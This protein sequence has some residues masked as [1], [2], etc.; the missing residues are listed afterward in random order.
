MTRSHFSG[1]RTH[2]YPRPSRACGTIDQRRIASSSLFPLRRSRRRRRR[3]R[4]RAAAERG[5]ERNGFSR[6]RRL[7][8]QGNKHYTF[9]QVL[10][11]HLST[12]TGFSQG[13]EAAFVSSLQRSR[14]DGIVQTVLLIFASWEICRCVGFNTHEFV[15]IYNATSTT[16]LHKTSCLEFPASL[17]KLLETLLMLKGNM[18]ACPCACWSLYLSVSVPIPPT[19]LRRG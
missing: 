5:G 15:Y 18:R 19:P 4:S 9:L 17:A 12:F 16:N 3:S 11:F 2:L 14:R 10:C 7:N 6:G 8:S 13:R 1:I